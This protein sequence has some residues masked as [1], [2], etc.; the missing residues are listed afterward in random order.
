MRQ[1]KNIFNLKSFFIEKSFVFNFPVFETNKTKQKAW[2]I[3]FVVEKNI[4]KHDF[5]I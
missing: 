2:I 5:F 4:I 1:L 3:Y